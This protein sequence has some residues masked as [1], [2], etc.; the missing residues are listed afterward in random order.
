[1]APKL[2][3]A[4]V[5][6]IWSISWGVHTRRKRLML[7]AEIVEGWAP[8]LVFSGPPSGSPPETFPELVVSMANSC[9]HP[10]TVSQVA[11]EWRTESGEQKTMTFNGTHFPR[12]PRQKKDDRW[13]VVCVA[14]PVFIRGRGGNG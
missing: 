3:I 14:W 2:P 4:A 13:S 6:L 9:S 7:E 11:V 8:V 10:I 12:G 1:M 5:A